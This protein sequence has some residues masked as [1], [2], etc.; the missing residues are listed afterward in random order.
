MRDRFKVTKK[1][2]QN[3]HRIDISNYCST[4]LEI[5]NYKIN[6][7]IKLN[8]NDSKIYVYFYKDGTKIITANNMFEMRQP[9]MSL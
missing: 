4:S 9:L 5:K 1:Y 3:F 7:I 6:L 2:N 8:Q